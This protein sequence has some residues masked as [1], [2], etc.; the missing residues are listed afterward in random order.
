[1]PKM[2]QVLELRRQYELLGPRETV[3][4]L[5][6]ALEKK[7]IHPEDLSIRDLAEALIPDGTEYVRSLDPRRSSSIQEAAGAVDTS[8]FSHI[9]GQLAFTAIRKAYENPVFVWPKLCRTEK[10]SFNGERIPGMSNIGD[11]AQIV[12]ETK[13]YP[14]AGVSEDYIDTPVTTKRGLIVP[15]TKEAIFFDRTNLVLDRCRK[16]GEAL[17]I[18]KEKR[19]IDLALGVVNNHNWKG[20]AYD[21]YQATT[22]WVNVK[23]SNALANYTNID[24]VLQVF[25]ALI[26]PFTSEPI[27]I[28]PNAILCHS[29]KIATA[30]AILTATQVRQDPNAALGTAKIVTIGGTPI[31]TNYDIISSA[32]IDARMTAAS[33]A[34]TSWYL[35]DFLGAFSYMENWPIT[36][37]QS[38]P[39]SEDAFKRD[40]VTQFKASERGVAAV[41]EPRRVVKSNA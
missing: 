15:V 32:L 19:C 13:D 8:A 6:E 18:N 17:G 39:N 22:S 28:V 16:V 20:V 30:R 27:L 5:T 36:V 21:T 34:A 24:A 14:L 3:S 41:K 37:E 1:M 11:K 33:I 10:T 25:G 7:Q 38:P 29:S 40:I 31:D 2:I 26:D 12:E 4:R 35:G 9:T 23:A